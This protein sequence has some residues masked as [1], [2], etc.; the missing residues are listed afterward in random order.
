M[1]R[2]FLTKLTLLLISSL[3]VSHGTIAP[4]LPGIADYFS[5]IPH[6]DL[7]SKMS[8][9][10]SALF[11]G[12]VSPLAG[13]ILDR[14]G[15][16]K[17]LYL[18][19]IIFSFSG[20]S[21]VFLDNLYVILLTRII[22]GGALGA[23]ITTLVTL[24]G[25]YYQGSE[26]QQMSGLLS[27]FIS[28]GGIIYIGSGGYLADISWRWPFLL[29]GAGVL[30][31]PLGLIFF[32]EPE[33]KKNT[34]LE[35]EDKK[36]SASIYLILL[37]IGSGC[38]ISVFFIMIFTQLPFVMK[39]LGHH[40][41]SMFGIVAILFNVSSIVTSLLYSKI[42]NVLSFSRIYALMFLFF[43]L[44]YL[45]LGRSESFSAFLLGSLVS[46]F[47]MG[48]I[49]S[50]TSFWLLSVT[51]IKIRGKV[52]GFMTLFLFFGQFISPLLVQ[53]LLPFGSLQDIFTW[54]AYLLFGLSGLYL[55]QL[56]TN[57]EDNT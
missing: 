7:L 34:C 49:N 56:K 20:V 3:W 22:L 53:L 13:F 48:F 23:L 18:S 21:V 25:D 57:G 26:R 46:G 24:V 27:A 32:K 42:K 47:G 35:S 19:L 2:T 15:R 10:I 51:H 44:G 36:Q 9:T 8:L 29:Y 6:A 33:P 41:N 45:I 28:L 31:L 5:T 16:L 40:K 50:N 30:L 37:I 12:L 11:V 43:G 39:D 14:F 54:S 17:T 52:M 55:I 38:L 4:C 1:N